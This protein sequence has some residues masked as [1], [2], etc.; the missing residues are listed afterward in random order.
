MWR[1]RGVEE[2]RRKKV[3]RRG[4]WKKKNCQEDHFRSRALSIAV[5]S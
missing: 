5:I 4:E 2:S 1:R 3:L